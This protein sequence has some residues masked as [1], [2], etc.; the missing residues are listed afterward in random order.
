M[1]DEEFVEDTAD[2]VDF[3]RAHR[4]GDDASGSGTGEGSGQ[5]A[6]G[7][8]ST[9]GRASRSQPAPPAQPAQPA[10]GTSAFKALQAH[11]L[12]CISWLH[13]SADVF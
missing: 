7:M 10:P 1:D 5:Q 6:A 4:D 8:R 11:T 3:V 9:R 12:C 13:G 2:V